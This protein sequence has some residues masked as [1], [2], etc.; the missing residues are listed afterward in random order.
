MLI[1]LNCNHPMTNNSY[2]EEHTHEVNK[3]KF[4][5]CLFLEIYFSETTFQTF[6]CLFVISKVNQRKTHSSQKKI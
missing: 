2:R 4:R 1:N 5:L 6:L 3:N